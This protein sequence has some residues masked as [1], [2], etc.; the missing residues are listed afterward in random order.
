MSFSHLQRVPRNKRDYRDMLAEWDRLSS[1]AGEAKRRA[2][3]SGTDS[4]VRPYLEKMQ[5]VNSARSNWLDRYDHTFSRL[6]E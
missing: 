2:N 6:P 3:A 4:Q 5:A 1:E